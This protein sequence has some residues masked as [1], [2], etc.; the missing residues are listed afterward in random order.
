MDESME[1]RIRTRPPAFIIEWTFEDFDKDS[2]DMIPLTK[3]IDRNDQQQ[4][5]VQDDHSTENCKALDKWCDEE[6]SNNKKQKGAPV[7]PN[8]S[9]EIT[10]DVTQERGRERKSSGYHLLPYF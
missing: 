10:S 7:A 4:Q 1:T 6:L 3:R 2:F 5:R 8:R 9:Q